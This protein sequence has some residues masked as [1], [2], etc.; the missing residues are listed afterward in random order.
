MVSPGWAFVRGVSVSPLQRSAIIAGHNMGL[1]LNRLQDTLR[2]AGIGLR[3][4]AIV[5]VRGELRGG[6]ETA[7][8][9]SALRRNFRPSADIMQVSSQTQRTRYR[10]YGKVHAY[11]DETGASQVFNSNFGDDELL[12]RIEIEERLGGIVEG[13]TL[14]YGMSINR[15]ELTGAARHQG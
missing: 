8:R 6:I 14:K 13:I 15:I 11:D 5:E 12:S 10:Y 2:A 9:I 4:A 3:R 1:S 7:K